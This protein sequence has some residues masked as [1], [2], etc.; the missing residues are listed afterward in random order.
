MDGA[1]QQAPEQ[2][3][4]VP[5]AGAPGGTPQEQPQGET[6]PPPVATK[7][8][9][10]VDVRQLQHGL[11][12]YGQQNSDAKKAV[13]LEGNAPHEEYMARLADLTSAS[14]PAEELD[15][16]V[17]E[18]YE[19]LYEQSWTSAGR[20]FGADLA[21][22]AQNVQELVYNT[23]DPY[24]LTKALHEMLT[25]MQ[26]GEEGE[27]PAPPSG[28]Q[29]APAAAAQQQAAPKQASQATPGV[30][31]EVGEPG[32]IAKPD[33]DD[34]AGSGDTRGFFQRVLR[35]PQAR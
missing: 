6:T 24:E 30:D 3:A 31:M 32:W 18:Q 33:D 27:A 14:A 35:Q 34:K 9:P 7:P 12:R 11:T 22:Q 8:K 16:A 5:E 13:G 25:K 19:A 1:S 10:P 4:V 29:P 17:A 2:N 26:T 20:D 21:T 15:P 28:Q 23:Q